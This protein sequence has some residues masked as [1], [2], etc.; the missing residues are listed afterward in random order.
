MGHW[1]RVLGFG[2]L[3]FRADCRTLGEGLQ[4][5]V[6]LSLRRSFSCIRRRECSDPTTMEE[7]AAVLLTWLQINAHLDPE[8]HTCTNLH[9]SLQHTELIFSMSISSNTYELSAV[10]RGNS[11]HVYVPEQPQPSE[12]LVAEPRRPG[13][14]VLFGAPLL[15]TRIFKNGQFSATSFQRRALSSSSLLLLEQY[16]RSNGNAFHNPCDIELQRLVGRLRDDRF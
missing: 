3:G 16:E 11:H 12:H 13:Q 5:G 1:F 9:M 7:R 10:V 6:D 8:Q 4:E 2:G 14:A 15:R